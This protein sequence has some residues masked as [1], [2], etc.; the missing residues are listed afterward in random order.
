V[1]QDVYQTLTKNQISGQIG[2]HHP[3]PAEARKPKP[4]ERRGHAR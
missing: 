2:V 4:L 1:T 3:A